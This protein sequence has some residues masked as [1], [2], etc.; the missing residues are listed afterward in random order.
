M[1]RVKGSKNKEALERPV[2]SSLSPQERINLLAHLIIDK[3]QEDQKNGQ[4]I[5]KQL[6]KQ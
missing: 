5:L 2:T 3:I 6:N 4:P 1:G